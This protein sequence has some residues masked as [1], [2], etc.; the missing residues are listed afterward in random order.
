MSSVPSASALCSKPSTA[1]DRKTED[2]KTENKQKNS[3]SRRPQI[4]VLVNENSNSEPTRRYVWK[5]PP[6]YEAR[7]LNTSNDRH[8][9]VVLRVSKPPR[10]D[11]PV[12]GTDPLMSMEFALSFERQ[13]HS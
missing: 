10:E 11:L 3:H 1:D 12:Y 9:G 13:K 4:P 8:D 5:T 6:E 2:S 7:N